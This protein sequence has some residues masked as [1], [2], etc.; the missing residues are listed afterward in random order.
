MDILRHIVPPYQVPEPAAGEPAPVLPSGAEAGGETAGHAPPAAAAEPAEA[1]PAA[2]PE[3]ETMIPVATFVRE[4]TPLRAKA[5]EAEERAARA[6]REL[7]AAKDML[8]RRSPATA[9]DQPATTPPAAV[10]VPPAADFQAAV[11]AEAAQQRLV[12]DVFSINVAGA[13]QFGTVWNE[14]VNALASYGADTYDFMA[15][16]LAVD[17]ANAHVILDEIARR[18]DLGMSLAGMPSRQRV[19]EL[20]KMSAA[21]S[22]APAITEPAK[23]ATPAKAI[24]K[25]PPPPPALEPSSTKVVDWRSDDASDADFSRGWEENQKTRNYRR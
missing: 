5:R 9:A 7:Q 10:P 4:V 18:P 23:P 25:A 6:E 2:S 24:S 14:R 16:V 11:R 13:R 15:D 3:P 8:A 17:R 19:V 12:E 20:A 21:K 22:A 1:E